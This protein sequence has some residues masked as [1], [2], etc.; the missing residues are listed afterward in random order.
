MLEFS[1]LEA[2]TEALIILEQRAC[3]TDTASPE[4]WRCRCAIDTIKAL[5]AQKGCETFDPAVTDGRLT[6]LCDLAI[7]G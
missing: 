2:L 1:T 7:F 3:E 6:T 5:V 4:G